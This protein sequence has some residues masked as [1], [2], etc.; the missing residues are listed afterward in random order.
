MMEADRDDKCGP[1]R[2]FV[3]GLLDRDAGVDVSPFPNLPENVDPAPG[4][5]MQFASGWSVRWR[6]TDD[7]P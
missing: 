2:M 5:T 6:K 4:S 3:Y 7:G 1:N